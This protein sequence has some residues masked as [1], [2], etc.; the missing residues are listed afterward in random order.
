MKN[1]S[2]TVLEAAKAMREGGASWKIVLE[3]T[4]LNYSQA[5]LFIERSN[6]PEDLDLSAAYGENPS[7]TVQAARA[8]GNSWGLI[9][10][11]CNVPESQVRKN[12]TAGT[13]LLSQGL[14]IG[15]GGRWFL[16]EPTL[17]A[18]NL[19]KPGTAIDADGEEP[20]RVRAV[21]AS[22]TQ[23]LISQDWPMLK[24]MAAELNVPFKKG[25]TKV[26]FCQA[27][28]AAQAK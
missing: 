17:Y 10:V 15:K 5:W 13:Q 25:M 26:K 28:L 22:R 2:A 23:R 12:F 6:L 1:P 3:E 9:A 20:V 21:E 19:A 18:E 11:R 7:G 8:E 4:G 14:R 16:G 24:A 27:I